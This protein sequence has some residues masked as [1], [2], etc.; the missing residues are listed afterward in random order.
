[1]ALHGTWFATPALARDQPLQQ[2]P[3]ENKRGINHYNNHQK[4]QLKGEEIKQVTSYRYLG[5]HLDNLF[6]WSDHIDHV[7]MESVIRYGMISAHSPN[8][9]CSA[10]YRLL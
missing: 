1:M 8:L 9:S 10:W 6:S 3:P 2:Q 5:I 7:V 4:K